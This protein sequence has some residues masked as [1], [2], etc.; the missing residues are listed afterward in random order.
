MLSP[1]GRRRLQ[2]AG[3][4]DRKRGGADT[5]DREK[6]EEDKPGE[7]RKEKPKAEK[8]RKQKGEGKASH[9]WLSR[10]PPPPRTHN[11]GTKPGPAELQ[12]AQ[13]SQSRRSGPAGRLPGLPATQISGPRSLHPPRAWPL[14]CPSRLLRRPRPEELQSERQQ[15]EP[16]GA[17]APWHGGGDPSRSVLTHPRPCQPP[18]RRRRRLVW[19]PRLAPRLPTRLSQPSAETLR[20]QPRGAPLGDGGGEAPARRGLEGGAGEELAGLG[21]AGLAQ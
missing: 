17:C 20:P 2:R 14:T 15:A 8:Q 3:E 6:T 13:G 10:P 19:N 5:R 16:G 7:Q 21:G 18:A 4:R 1:L 9:A 12:E 11:V